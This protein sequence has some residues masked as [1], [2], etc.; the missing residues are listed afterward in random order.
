MSEIESSVPQLAEPAA[1]EPVSLESLLND[2]ADRSALSRFGRPGYGAKAAT[3]YDR[4]SK[5]NNPADGLYV[6]T[7]GRDWGKGWF[8]NRDF[9]HCIREEENGGRK[10][11]V[12][13]EDEGP[14]AIVRWW[15]PSCDK[16]MIRVYLDGALTP[17]LEMK[18]DDLVGSNN[19]RHH[20]LDDIPFTTSELIRLKKEERSNE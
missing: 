20:S 5:V 8:A 12:I 11:S 6:E 14:G 1:S 17:V 3:S 2:M 16:G 7:S 19:N 15:A 9:G 18:P 13:M 4:E 10:E